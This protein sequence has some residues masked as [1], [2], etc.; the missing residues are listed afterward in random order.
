MI[1]VNKIALIPFIAFGI[2]SC[3][4][5]PDTTFQVSDKGNNDVLE[6]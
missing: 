3:T 2:I 5:D 4:H 6:V 1:N